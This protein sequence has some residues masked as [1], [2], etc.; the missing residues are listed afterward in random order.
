MNQAIFLSESCPYIHMAWRAEQFTI[1]AILLVSTFLVALTLFKRRKKI[2]KNDLALKDGWQSYK[3]NKRAKKAGFET[4]KDYS[5]GLNAGFLNKRA[6]QF[7]YSSG[8]NSVDSMT[9]YWQNAKS[10]INYFIESDTDIMNEKMLNDIT[11]LEQLTNLENHLKPYFVEL[12]Q[13]IADT[14]SILSIQKSLLN[15]FQSENSVLFT[16]LRYAQ[17][18]NQRIVFKKIQQQ[19]KIIRENLNSEFDMRKNWFTQWQTYMQPMWVTGNRKNI[20]LKNISN[21]INATLD[22]EEYRLLNLLDAQKQKESLEVNAYLEK[23]LGF[24]IVMLMQ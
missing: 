3:Q 8:F 23:E 1:I 18:E 7:L 20:S 16:N 14:N 22:D 24:Q 4:P 17:L 21:I 13:F 9:M 11:T 10:N 2:M 15:L 12:N 6:Q 19:L 5:K